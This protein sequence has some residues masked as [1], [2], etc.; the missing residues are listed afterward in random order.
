L[1]DLAALQTLCQQVLCK[2]EAIVL[3]WLGRELAARI[4]GQNCKSM[5]SW[6][7]TIAKQELN[8]TPKKIQT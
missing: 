8:V 7:Q 5:Q 6:V 4:Q 2:R 1:H 3:K